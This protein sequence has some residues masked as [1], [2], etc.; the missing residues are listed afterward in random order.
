MTSSFEAWE[1]KARQAELL[2]SIE[3]AVRMAEEMS[4]PPQ[5]IYVGNKIREEVVAALDDVMKTRR[6]RFDH[7]QSS[8]EP[9]I[10][11]VDLKFRW[12]KRGY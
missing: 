10:R 1:L 11:T 9:R 12:E 2:E 3:D 7:R 6:A 8:E 4:G 5:P